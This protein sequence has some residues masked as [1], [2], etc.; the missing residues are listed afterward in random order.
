MQV[1]AKETNCLLLLSFRV[2]ISGLVNCFV[3]LPPPPSGLGVIVFFSV[4][5]YDCP[6]QNLVNATAPTVLAGYAT[7][8]TFLA[9]SFL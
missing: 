2:G 1:L 8:P 6:S 4:R 5:P 3:I 9:G 7:L